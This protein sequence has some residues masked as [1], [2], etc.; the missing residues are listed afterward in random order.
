MINERELVIIGHARCKKTTKKKYL[1]WCI[2]ALHEVLVS[3]LNLERL[4]Y[5]CLGVTNVRLNFILCT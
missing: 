4:Y 2:K 3:V 5:D 1:Y